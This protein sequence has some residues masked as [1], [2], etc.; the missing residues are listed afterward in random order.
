MPGDVTATA[1]GLVYSIVD[2]GK[3]L[4]TANPAFGLHRAVSRKVSAWEHHGTDGYLLGLL[5]GA[6][7]AGASAG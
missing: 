5:G 7:D 3:N 4:T 6:F 2:T 1:A